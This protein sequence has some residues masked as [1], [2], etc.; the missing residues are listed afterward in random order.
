M[1]VTVTQE[2]L[3]ILSTLSDEDILSCTIENAS[4]TGLIGAWY[5]TVV[6]AKNNIN[7]NTKLGQKM[8]E[9][10]PVLHKYIPEGHLKR[11]IEQSHL[12]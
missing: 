2:I 4:R 9:K 1:S 11:R 6:V 10:L 7:I 5:P 3:D 8:I 12:E